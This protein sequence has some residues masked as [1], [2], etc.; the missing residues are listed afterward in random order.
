MQAAEESHVAS[1]SSGGERLDLALFRRRGRGPAVVYVH[2]ATF[3]SALAVGWRMHGRSWL[4]QLHAAGFDAWAFDFAGYGASSR[5][6]AFARP[7]DVSPPFGDSVAAA[8]QLQHVLAYVRRLRPDAPIHVVAHSWGT[9]PAQ[10]V[11][12]EHT[13]LMQ[14]LVLFG[15][16]VTRAGKREAPV[17]HAWHLVT[18]EMQRPRHRTG[19]PLS[20][21]TPVGADELERWCTAYQATDHDAPTRSPSAVKVPSGPAADVARAWSGERLVDSGHLLQ[22]TLIVRGEW[23][24]VTTD[25]DARALFDALGTHAKRDV[26]ISGGNHWLHLQPRRTVLWDETTLFLGGS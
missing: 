9:L 22:P 17:D 25:Q 10:R 14:R 7:A 2:G 13:D 6:A 21:P 3:P 23:D 15:P 26:K 16:V 20:E 12:I 11:A 24:H 4:D 1:W 5:P 19:L 18:S 8:S